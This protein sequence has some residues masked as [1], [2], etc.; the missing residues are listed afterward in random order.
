MKVPSLGRY[1]LALLI[2]QRTQQTNCSVIHHQGI[3]QAAVSTHRC[4]CGDADAPLVGDVRHL[5]GQTGQEKSI[6]QG[7]AKPACAMH[8]SHARKKRSWAGIYDH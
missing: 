5:R 3:F 4:A 6:I 8:V 1:G 7:R 2:R